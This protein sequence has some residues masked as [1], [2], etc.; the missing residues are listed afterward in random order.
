MKHILK[1]MKTGLLLGTTAMILFSSCNKDLEQ[2]PESPAPGTPT[3]AALADTIKSRAS[4]SLYYRLIIKSGLAATLNNKTTSYTM[5]VPDNNGMKL[6]INAISGGL[7]PLNAPDAV[8]SGFIT[9]NI[10]AA[11]AAGLVSYNTCPQSLASTS[12][13]ST[14]PNFQYPCIINPAPTVSALARL[15]TFPTTRN[16]AWVNNVPIT[17]VDMQAANGVIHHVAT[18]VAPPQRA[19]WERIN[20]DA[21]LTIM[22][23]A[24]ARA[25]SGVAPV[26]SSSLIWA[27]SN[28]G[29]NLTVF[30][31]TNQAMKNAISF[32]TGGLLPPNAPDIAF[33]GF[34]GSNNI[35]TQTV[36]G[37]IV[38][39]ILGTGATF[40]NNM[41]TTAA[42]F[43]TLLNTAVPT[44]P[45]VSLVCTLTPGLGVT[46]AKV[47][48]VINPVASNV[49]VNPTPDANPSYGSTIPPAFTYT[50]TSD[51]FYINGTLHKIDQV[52]LPQ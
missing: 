18:I 12:I 52:L 22:K 24:I 13:P 17:G 34:L 51:Q 37:L 6:F 2:F 40:L 47:K 9:A 19:M 38:Y 1:S 43:P 44:H 21:D 11:T 8:F 27:L 41:P 45:G 49:L 31:P 46:A 10:P 20:T 3:Y 33:I 16:G 50:G 32:L 7:V 30:A 39:H 14:F 26:N 23:A 35:T 42:S 4:D 25:D 5:F 15:T 29:P 48:G 36:K 28:F